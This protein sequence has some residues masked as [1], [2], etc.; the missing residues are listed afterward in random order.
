MVGLLYRSHRFDLSFEFYTDTL[1]IRSGEDELAWKL[2]ENAPWPSPSSVTAEDFEAL[3][4]GHQ[5]FVCCHEGNWSRE[6]GWA[7]WE[8]FPIPGGL[9]VV[10]ELELTTFTV[11]GSPIARHSS[12]IP[13]TYSVRDDRLEFCDIDGKRTDLSLPDLKTLKSDRKFVT[14]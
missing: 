7:I 8:I 11:G 12:E 13:N 10:E 2:P 3:V 4:F 14:D 1:L 9:L 5:M 6:S